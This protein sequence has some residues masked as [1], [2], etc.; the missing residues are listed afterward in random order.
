MAVAFSSTVE[1][2]IFVIRGGGVVK[3]DELGHLE[4]EREAYFERPDCRRLFLCDTSELRVISPEA[5]EAIVARMQ[6]D[7]DRV[8]RSA[9][10]V[11][12]GTAALQ[13]KRIL[14]DAGSVKRRVFTS[15]DQALAWLRSLP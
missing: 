3:L 13:M 12:D 15:V 2:G 6:S 7:N 1:D 11:S 5:S 4:A 9:F 8:L 10:V 14:R